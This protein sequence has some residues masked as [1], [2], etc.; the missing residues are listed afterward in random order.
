MS[1]LCGV[2]NTS[3]AAPEAAARVAA[4]APA[5]W[6]ED[7]PAQVESANGAALL[8]RPGVD[9]ASVAARDGKLAAIVGQP[10][11]R[12]VELSRMA[13]A[14]G[15]AVAVLEANA[16]YGQGLLDRLEG[17]FT[18]AV[19]APGEGQ[20]WA[21]IDR[22]GVSSLV[23]TV[24]PDGAFVFSTAATAVAAYPGQERRLCAQSLYNYLYFYTVP[25][26]GTIFR[27]QTRL[28]PGEAAGFADGS[29]SSRSYW[30][31]PY[32]AAGPEDAEAALPDLLDR[33]VEDSIRDVPQ[34]SLG[35][36]LS[37]G[38]DS[39][40]VAGFLARH[41]DQAR[42]YTIRFDDEKYDEGPF[43][44]IAA[45]H[46]A[47]RHRDYFVTPED[48]ARVLPRIADVFDEPFGN[49]SAVPVYYCAKLAADDGVGVMLAGDG[50]DEI[51]A[52]N[53]RYAEMDRFDRYGR[54]PAALRRFL[55]DPILLRLPQSGLGSL[56]RAARLARR[57]HMTIPERLYSYS[58][59]PRFRLD[60]VL[61]ERLIAE[62]DDG[63][64]V[65]LATEAFDRPADGDRVQ[66]MMS[67]DLQFA[68][69]N[70]DLRKV[71]RMCR[72]AGVSVR[73]PMLDPELTAFAAGL[74][75]SL[76][77]PAGRLRGFYKDSMAGFLPQAI[78]DKPKHGFGL[79]FTTWVVRDDGL[80]QM[81]GDLLAGMRKRRIMT[82]AYLDQLQAALHA[83]ALTGL[84]DSAW[85]IAVLELWL[86]RHTAGL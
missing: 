61:Q 75:A 33:A 46:F 69:A 11:W 68:L 4:M 72:L 52:G 5:C 29:A 16:R 65:R 71:T 86:E 40:S 7:Q 8:V 67:L 78:I 36:F 49:T 21:A 38:L 48:V 83:E 37:G 25:A 41:V 66:R 13:R 63:V 47:T 20:A 10:R 84:Q 14:E 17:S 44:N 3:L 45:G 27:G 57:Y 22:F 64:P 42:T 30:S 77:M 79:P 76:L 43:A 19:I 35:A 6:H 34:T 28:R 15:D 31:M 51:F 55:F 18:V 70:N 73:F 58:A 1:D 80:R 59:F 54:I 26:P 2:L 74:P 60:Q 50:G 9:R 39:S 82:D 62:I 56:S 81:V 53:E 85:D 12:D 23:W 24:A 32:G